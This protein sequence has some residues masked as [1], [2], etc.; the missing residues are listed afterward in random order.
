MY[1]LKERQP[2]LFETK[3]YIND[4]LL[5]INLSR[6][7]AEDIKSF[8]KKL[9]YIIGPYDADNSIP[10]ISLLRLTCIAEQE[11]PLIHQLRSFALNQQK[12]SLRFHRFSP[13]DSTRTLFIDMPNKEP[14][15]SFQQQLFLY[16]N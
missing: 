14:L 2:A 9:S 12:L 5:L 11:D 1:V 10:H 4:Y 15:M 7:L 13:L 6:Q 8:R 16:L 3:V